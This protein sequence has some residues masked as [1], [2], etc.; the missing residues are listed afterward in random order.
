MKL[1]EKQIQK[2]R[3]LLIEWEDKNISDYDYCN[4]AGKILGLGKWTCKG[5]LKR[6]IYRL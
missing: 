5:K 3:T 6:E 1:T 2:L 4:N